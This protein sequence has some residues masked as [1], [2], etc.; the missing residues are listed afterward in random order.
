[1]LADRRTALRGVEHCRVTL[2]AGFTTV[3]NVG[4]G[5]HAAFALRDGIA[6]GTE[7][8]MAGVKIGSV[9]SIALNPETYL[10]D[11]AHQRIIG[12]IKQRGHNVIE[13]PYDGPSYLGGSLRC[14]SQPIR[15]AAV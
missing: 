6:A 9:R 3:R 13:I 7:V 12:E 5:G 11:S 1:M 15:R 2:H 4:S 10:I 8:R 14:S